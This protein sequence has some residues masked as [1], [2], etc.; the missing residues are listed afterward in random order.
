MES[1][2]EEPGVDHQDSFSPVIYNMTFRII[3]V[4]WMKYG[5]EAEI[6]DI[7]TAF[8]YRN[9]REEIYFKIPD[10]YKKY[11]SKKSDK[12]DCII[13]DQTIYGLMQAARQFFK[14]ND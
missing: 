13:L 1:H 6:I 8:L 12:N 11:T 7:E 5:W 4:M 10:G 3:L 9:L 14:K 2:E